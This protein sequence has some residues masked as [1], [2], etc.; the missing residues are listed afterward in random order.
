MINVTLSSDGS[1]SKEGEGALIQSFETNG[2][3]PATFCI[4]KKKVFFCEEKMMG[5]GMGV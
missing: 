1:S 4:L 5:A 3:W 2:F